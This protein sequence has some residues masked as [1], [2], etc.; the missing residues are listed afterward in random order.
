[1]SG[2]ASTPYSTTVGG[3]DFNWCSLTTSTECTPAPYWNSTNAANGSSA[4]G[5][6]PEVPW[7]NTCANPLAASFLE[8]QWAE[9]L[10][11][12][13]VTNPETA[14]N[15]VADYY[16]Y[17]YNYYGVDLSVLVDTVGGS[18]GASGCVVSDSAGDCTA[19][20][21]STGPTT[22]PDTGAAQ[23]S[24]PLYNNGWPKPS[25]Q[26]GVPGIPADGVRDIPDVSF[27]ASNG[28]LSSSAYLICV[29][30][31][32]P[33]TYTTSSEPFAQEVGGT[34]VATPAMAGVMALINQKT[35]S[36]QGSP[37]AELYH[38][39][40]QQTY[41]SC[42]AETAT[43]GNGCS[44]NDIDMGNNAAPCD[45]GDFGYVSPDCRV[46]YAAD[47]GGVGILS[48]Y[49]AG[50]GYD[51]ATGLG[52]LNVAN[53]VNNWTSSIGSA[54]ATVTVT[55]AENTLAS[56][57]SLSVTVTVA[58][59]PAGGATPTGTVTLSGG[60]YTSATEPLSGGTYTFT[61]PAGS[62]SGG[63]DT[64]TASYSGDATYAP[65]SGTAQ[66]T[67]TKL[68]PTVTVTPASNAINSNQTL[69]VTGTV[70]GTGETPTGTVTLSG[71]GY[72]S[73]AATLSSGSYSITIP[74][75]SLSGGSDTLAVLYSGD[76]TY[77]SQS[78]AATVTV[79]YV[80]VLTPTVTVAPA[81]NTLDSASSLTVT[82]TVTG[83]AGNPTPTGFVTLSGGGYTSMTQQL[84]G[85][86][87]A[88]T[89]P[90][91]SLNIGTDP[92]TVAYS[93]DANYF[94]GS[95][96]SSVTVTESTYTVAA[97]AAAAISTPGG[98]STST[99]TV[100]TTTGYAG[101][102]T[103]TCTLTGYALGDMYLPSCSIP[104][105]AVPM[106]GTATATINTT[107][108]SSSELAYPDLPGKDRGWAGAG[109]AVL[110]L[111]VFLGIPARRRGWRS[112]LGV[113]AVLAILGSL[114]A[115]GG[116]GGGGS[117]TTTTIPGTTPDTYTFTVTATGTPSVTPEPSTTFSVTVD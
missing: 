77:N 75:N 4:K 71:G 51:Q 99:V 37:N 83:G 66:V 88:F 116:G 112:M 52:S 103:L 18:G 74:Y 68:T 10:G 90:P 81:F 80:A 24:L 92:L 11:I 20:A 94:L 26:A 117:T 104:G 87:Y 89:I 79:T 95:G 65:E 7:N 107:A 64:L 27:F 12:S 22:N 36:P 16:Q 2:L 43:T 97:T 17:I 78:G 6:V 67:V 106:G 19:G 91:Y 53:V 23:A 62:L 57:Q 13:G 70:T 73:P 115:C 28:L 44:F 41:T 59:S 46:L 56:S 14:C 63:S 82:A 93:G 49:S 38:L 47:Q 69:I 76:A 1:M 109:G 34:S 86:V 108:A 25:W 54:T 30:D 39:A 32:A 96:V 50:V 58:S 9:A 101:T 110:A 102:V 42:S 8:T 55:P 15:F 3:T 85:G 114:T 111:L 45:D 98:S 33:C 72:T 21:S 40:A 113:L 60:G 31:V 105:A 84:V 29:S 61:I 5:Y 48:G 100:N 35:G